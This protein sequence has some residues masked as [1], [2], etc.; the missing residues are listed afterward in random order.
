MVMGTALWTWASPVWIA[1][2]PALCLYFAFTGGRVDRRLFVY[3]LGIFVWALAFI[4]PIGVLADGYLF[5]AHM[6]QHLL[7]L[8]V[9]P[10]CLV[11]SLS[12]R[13]SV[14]ARN[15]GP[16]NQLGRRASKPVL[17]W[18]AGVGAMWFWH[19]PWLCSA[20]ALNPTVA[21]IRDA[22][23]ILAG[24]LFW[25]PIYAP[26]KSC[27]LPELNGMVYLFSACLGCTVLGIYLTFA[28]LSVCPA[29]ANPADRLGILHVLYD[30]GITPGVDQHLGGLIMWVPPCILYT[31]AIISLLGRWYSAADAE[32][33]CAI[34]G[35]QTSGAT[36]AI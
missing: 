23:L 8:L 4:S 22:S 32:P 14:R 10:L 1:I 6:M 29:F 27:R 9:V 17:S 3:L 30:A 21:V 18:T 35:S 20:A 26:C 25:W 15:W 12:E 11:L 36:H 31:C 13:E 24:V 19:L 28:P 33:A 16:F 34:S 2:V 5:S 7:L